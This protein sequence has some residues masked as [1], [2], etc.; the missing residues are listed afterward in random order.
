MPFLVTD[1]EAQ[2][3]E[4]PPLP[5]LERLPIEASG[6]KAGESMPWADRATVTGST[7]RP[8]GRLNLWYRSPAKEWYEALPLGNGRLGAMIFGGVTDDCVQLNV[9]S[10]WDG[11]PKDAS[12]PAALKVLPEI[13]RLLFEGKNIEATQLAGI[14]MMGLPRNIK[15]YQTLGE[16][17][18]EAPG[19]TAATG[20]LRRL[21]LDTAIAHVTYES[22][23]VTYQR[24]AFVSAPANVIVLR[25][26]ASKPGAISLKL[27]LKRAKDAVCQADPARPNAIQLVG[28]I[29]RDPALTPGLR[30]QATVLARNQ[31]GRVSN[32]GG[33]LSVEGADALTLLIAAGTNFPGLGKGA[34]DPQRDPAIAVNATLAQ[35]PE[36]AALLR[37][38]LADYRPFFQRVALDLGPDA[39]GVENLTTLERLKRIKSGP[40]DPG[41]VS[42]YFQFGRYLLISS[43]RPG[44]LPANLQGIWAWKL[45]NPWDADF[46]TN[47]NIQMNYWLAEQANLAEMHLPLFDLMDSL[48]APGA[49]TAKVQYNAGGWVVHHLT[50]AWGFTACADGPHGIWPMGAAWLARHPWEHYL[51][52]GDEAFLK[53]R[54]WP[55]MKGAARFILDFL[56]EAPAGTPVA[57]KLITN[58]SHSPEN[59][60]FLPDG[61]TRAVFT[62]GAT[63]D[64]QIIHD[65]LT[66]CIE[67]S[68]ILNM[69]PEFR[70]ECE[71][72]L[73]RLAPVRISPATGRIQEWIEDYQECE[74]Q[75]RHTSHLYGLHPANAITKTT[76]EFFEAAR[77]VLVG[78]GDGGTGWSLAWKINMWA[79]LGDGDRAFLL[80]SNLLKYKTLPNLFD[81]HAPFQIDGNF[82]ATAA[83]V[84]ML[85][86]SQIRHHDPKS[87]PDRPE[88][89]IDLLP[90]LPS[91][92]PVGRVS[93]LRAR[94]GF[95]LDLTWKEGK[96]VQARVRSTLGGPLN[97]RSGEKT[98][99]VETMPGEVVEV[100]GALA[101]RRLPI[102]SQ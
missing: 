6:G 40:P 51:Y 38:H 4:T 98:L 10:L 39:P 8:E 101:V 55:L 61:K 23:G 84:E 76:P 46:H 63:M 44:T 29:Q 85:L 60:F 90:A 96:L 36:D 89:Q 68:M 99:R 3:P 7:G 70:Q 42:L 43:S 72:A 77:K 93:G 78:R 88:F 95:V 58:P 12:N 35:V 91:A 41:L 28:Q 30:F 71:R 79:R 33:I 26:T 102:E 37:D 54:A 47:I 65:L 14:H 92:W 25:Y 97:L 17:Y 49:Q 27:T 82:G 67:A 56:V 22:D 64:L 57:G 21:D 13:R 20:Y 48:V 45:N 73:A 18:L 94:G 52:T 81:T 53:N 80:L 15:S 24:E 19:Q 11:G 50:D 34:P 59:S 87:A 16:L 31:G 75:H 83:I 69:D 86:Q 74:P 9:D 62:Y 5:A 66:N 32:T 2:S 100:D 1:I